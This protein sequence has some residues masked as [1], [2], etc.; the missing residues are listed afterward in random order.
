MKKFAS[1]N[2]LDEKKVSEEI[3]FFKEIL[4]NSK[5]KVDQGLM[6]QL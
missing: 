1:Q 2:D 3:K 4:L 5:I 6:L